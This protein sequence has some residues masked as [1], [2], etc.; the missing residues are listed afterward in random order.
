MDIKTKSA[1]VVITALAVLLGGMYGLAA[2]DSDD[3]GSFTATNSG[4]MVLQDGEPVLRE[5]FSVPGSLAIMLNGMGSTGMDD[6][7]LSISTEGVI[8]TVVQ[9]TVVFEWSERCRYMVDIQ[10]S[11]E[12]LCSIA[13]TQNGKDVTD[14]VRGTWTEPGTPQG[15]AEYRVSMAFD[16]SE[17]QAVGVYSL[18]DACYGDLSGQAFGYRIVGQDGDVPVSG[19]LEMTYEDG[20]DDSYLIGWSYEITGGSEGFSEGSGTLI[21]PKDAAWSEG[22][23]SGTTD[24]DTLWG[25]RIADRIDAY[26]DE[27]LLTLYAADGIL[28]EASFDDGETLVILQ[29]VG[30]DLLGEPAP[31]PPT[32]S[33][34]MSITGS[35]VVEGVTM[36]VVGRT[37]TERLDST[38]FYS[39]VSEMLSI[40]VGGETMSDYS[41]TSWSED[42]DTVDC[43]LFLETR[44]ISTAWGDVE[45]EVFVEE[46]IGGDT[47]VFIYKGVLPLRIE[48][49]WDGLDG[50]RLTMV[51]ETD[52]LLIDGAKCDSIDAFADLLN[53]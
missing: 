32:C 28:Y 10:P 18:I 7:I 47:S 13:V 39:L 8:S 43:G 29:L 3:D 14:D 48:T 16:C 11:T 17:D 38:S 36:D 52:S 25:T 30:S 19:T 46:H 4:L 20:G 34:S 6:G 23:S 1:V 45:T 26:R 44:I 31:L 2:S 12:E 5:R 35:G 37:T 51:Y 24:I 40:A 49:A 33:Y 21:S 41:E 42:G 53:S 15:R 9:Y 27:G 22:I 50:S